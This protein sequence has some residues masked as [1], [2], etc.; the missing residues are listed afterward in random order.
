MRT[1][2][3][4][5]KL[6]KY[7]S[8]NTYYYCGYVD[9]PGY[10]LPPSHDHKYYVGEHVAGLIADVFNATGQPLCLDIPIKTL[11]QGIALC[12]AWEA[13]GAY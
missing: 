4:V 13:T 11:Q 6:G 1:N 5:W 2:K 7:Q 9:A 8:S 12:E 10:G 3:I